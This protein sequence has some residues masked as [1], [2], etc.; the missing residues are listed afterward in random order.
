[1]WDKSSSITGGKKEDLIGN[2]SGEAIGESLPS[3][4]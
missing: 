2:G 1:M 4:T 3:I